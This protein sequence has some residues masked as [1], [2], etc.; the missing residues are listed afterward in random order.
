ML[1]T[2]IGR[3]GR[4]KTSLVKEL[5]ELYE[6]ER[7]CILDFLGDYISDTDPS[8]PFIDDPR[9]QLS[10]GGVYP[11]LKNIWD[12]CEEYK[13]T[14]VVLDEIDCYSKYNKH[15]AFIY[16]YGRHAGIEM[17]AVSRTFMDLPVICR[18]LTDVYYLFQITEFIDLQYLSRHKGWEFAN[19]VKNLEFYEYKKIT[20]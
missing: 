8:K 15:I 13:G 7:I 9:I 12:T 1:T 4:G 5:V 19:K 14:L 3:R 6:G 10:R 2:I 16:K 18:R 20:L 11:F 17:I